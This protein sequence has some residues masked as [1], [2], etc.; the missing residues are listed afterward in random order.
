MT[1]KTATRRSSIPRR[2]RSEAA[3]AYTI[4]DAVDQAV[5]TFAANDA[6]CSLGDAYC[7][8]PD[9]TAWL[10]T[11]PTAQ[12][13]L[14]R[15]TLGLGNITEHATGQ[16]VSHYAAVEML[17]P[18]TKVFPCGD[19]RVKRDAMTFILAVQS[20]DFVRSAQDP[21]TMRW[22]RPVALDDDGIEFGD[23]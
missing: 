13:A 11:L 3:T 18:Q 5:Q 12:T 8:L 2:A 1:T 4:K 7:R 6:V 14:R 22:V 10:A 15:Y 16:V 17:P 21:D 9:L 23:V 20:L 19:A